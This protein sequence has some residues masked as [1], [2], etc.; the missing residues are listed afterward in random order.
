MIEAYKIVT[1]TV[2]RG[3]MV[4]GHTAKKFHK[5]YARTELCV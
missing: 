3:V 5:F 4:E 1:E 2:S